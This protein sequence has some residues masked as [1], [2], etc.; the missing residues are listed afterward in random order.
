MERACPVLSVRPVLSRVLSRYCPVSVRFS[1]STYSSFIC[2]FE[3][4]YPGARM[5]RTVPVVAHLVLSPTGM[6]GVSV[7]SFI[8]DK[9][10][11]V[12]DKF[13]ANAD[14]GCPPS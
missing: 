13:S 6:G 10:I 8:I 1:P 2:S 9:N 7:R 3:P 14:K 4:V 5:S 11:P 12:P